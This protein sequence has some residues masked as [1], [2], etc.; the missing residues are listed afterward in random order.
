MN[1]LFG[2]APPFINSF[3]FSPP[4]CSYMVSQDK[5]ICIIFAVLFL[6]H[7]K[8]KNHYLAHYLKW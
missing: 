1:D 4:I 5:K 3:F 2:S 6:E 7:Q 8:K